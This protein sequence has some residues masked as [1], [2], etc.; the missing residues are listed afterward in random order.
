MRYLYTLIVLVFICYSLQENSNAQIIP[1]GF[2][3]VI[4]FSGH[5]L[6]PMAEEVQKKCDKENLDEF[7]KV[8]GQCTEQKLAPN[9]GERIAPSRVFD[10]NNDGCANCEDYFVWRKKLAESFQE[11]VRATDGS[12]LEFALCTQQVK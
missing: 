3:C 10:I 9:P 12:E 4:G 7:A 11:K 5:I 2:G 6:N 8:F 1:T